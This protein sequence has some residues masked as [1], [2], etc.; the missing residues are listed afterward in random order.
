MDIL[1]VGVNTFARHIGL[2]GHLFPYLSR[3]RDWKLIEGGKS[4]DKT[5]SVF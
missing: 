3:D 4:R 1:K 2:T 5:R